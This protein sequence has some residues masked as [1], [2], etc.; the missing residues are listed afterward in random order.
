MFQLQS[1]CLHA[2]DRFQRGD[3]RIQEHQFYSVGRRWS[4]QDQASVE[5]LLPKHARLVSLMLADLFMF[6]LEICG[7]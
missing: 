6:G 3:G 2:T 4:G 5:A 1:F 7:H